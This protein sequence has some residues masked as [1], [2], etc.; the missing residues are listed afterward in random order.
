MLSPSFPNS[1][2]SQ[3]HICMKIY[4]ALTVG[5]DMK[6]EIDTIMSNSRILK[7]L[8]TCVS[9]L[10]KTFKTTLHNTIIRLS[11]KSF[12]GFHM[13]RL[14]RSRSAASRPKKARSARQE[15]DL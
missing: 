14:R 13:A 11:K 4:F 2:N 3:F 12:V 5:C 6:K 15:V 10:F 1:N 8:K 9:F 7:L